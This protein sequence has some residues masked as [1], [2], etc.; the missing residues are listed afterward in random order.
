ME[1]LS[2]DLGDKLQMWTT[3]AKK[4]LAQYEHS[5]GTTVRIFGS[6]HKGEQVWY[7]GTR[8]FYYD[9]D[10]TYDHKI[11]WETAKHL[12]ENV[13]VWDFM[14]SV[15]TK[16]AEEKKAAKLEKVVT[17]KACGCTKTIEELKTM[18]HNTCFDA[19]I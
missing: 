15:K 3:V 1:Q 2:L 4:M 17:C 5:S 9:T 10:Y 16:L 12:Y 13:N 14:D 7:L 6:I 18:D 11:D 19:G 8:T